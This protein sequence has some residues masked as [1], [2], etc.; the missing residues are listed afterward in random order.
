LDEEYASVLYEALVR[1]DLTARRLDR[2][3]EWL[4][5]AWNNSAAISKDARVLVFRAG[6]ASRRVRT[7]R[8]NA[9]KP[10]A[11]RDRALTSGFDRRSR[12]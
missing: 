5:L 3:I 12:L 7:G 10:P 2:A 9:S 4:A 1:Y 6:L 8:A 11:S